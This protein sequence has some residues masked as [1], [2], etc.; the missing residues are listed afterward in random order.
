MEESPV[1]YYSLCKPYKRLDMTIIKNQ[2]PFDR[3]RATAILNSLHIGGSIHNSNLTV[4]VVKPVS[5]L[6]EIAL[7]L[8][9]FDILLESNFSNLSEEDRF[10]VILRFYLATISSFS[11]DI[12]K[13]CTPYLGETFACFVSTTYGRVSFI[14][15][16]CSLHPHIT[17]FYVEDENHT[18]AIQSTIMPKGTFCGSSVSYTFGGSM[19]I[20]HL[21]SSQSFTIT[22]PTLVATNI[23]HDVPDLQVADIVT[24]TSSKG[25][26]SA[27]IKFLLQSIFGGDH[28]VVRV[29]V[30]TGNEISWRIGGRWDIGY[31]LTREDT[32]ESQLWMD[33][34]TLQKLPR[35]VCA[36][37]QQGPLES[38]KCGRW[39]DDK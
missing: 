33:I 14:A 36:L 39:G 31:E 30:R 3:S 35:W 34:N 29:I 23:D 21:P 9:H 8:D 32:Q 10:F 15:E 18:F 2:F 20:T 7:V 11:P 5:F 12:Y 38:L 37:D 24:V 19:T 4:D 26:F 6:E 25:V 27:Q 22:H 13:P 17:C 16:Q 28:R 1:D